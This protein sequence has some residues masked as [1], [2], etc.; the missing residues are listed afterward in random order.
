MPQLCGWNRERHRGGNAEL[1]DKL[2]KADGGPGLLR[3]EHMGRSGISRHNRRNARISFAGHSLSVARAGITSFRQ[4]F[5]PEAGTSFP[6]PLPPCH[7]SP[8]LP[9]PEPYCLQAV[10]IRPVAPWIC[11]VSGI[12]GPH[13]FSFQVSSPTGSNHPPALVLQ[14]KDESKKCSRMPGI[15][16][17]V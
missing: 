6:S 5:C 12:S 3:N 15:L 9:G 4:D 10:L 14:A 2:I 13:R 17:F 7:P 1:T 11:M 8:P 16:C